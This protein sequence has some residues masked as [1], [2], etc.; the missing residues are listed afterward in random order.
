MR[1]S[2]VQVISVAI[3]AGLFCS[4]TP[5]DDE[6]CGDDGRFEYMDGVCAPV[7]EPEDTADTDPAEVACVPDTDSDLEGLG[8]VCVGDG[9]C[10]GE[11]GF[12]L[13]QPGADE[14]YC[15]N[16]SCSDDPND[17]PCGFTCC[18][19]ASI[20]EHC[21]VDADYTL[22]SALGMCGGGK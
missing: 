20:G 3:V 13:T 11:Y 14:G 9:D 10:S 19:G 1:K 16:E 7:V 4:C 5:A 21:L 2:L 12:C 8:D 18:I 17:C 15:T 6:R 22:L